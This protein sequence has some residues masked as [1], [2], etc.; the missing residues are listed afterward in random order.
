MNSDSKSAKRL[1]ESKRQI[2]QDRN[3]AEQR[4][5]RR[6]V[7]RRAPGLQDSR[8]RVGSSSRRPEVEMTSACCAWAASSGLVSGV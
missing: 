1:S 3:W 4:Q 6:D 5:E 7:K 8:T 2:V